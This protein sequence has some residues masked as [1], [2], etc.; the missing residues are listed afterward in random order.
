MLFRE[1]AVMGTSVGSHRDAFFRRRTGSDLPGFTVR[2][3]LAPDVIRTDRV[4]DEVHPFAVWRPCRKRAAP[5]GGTYGE[6]GRPSIR[7]NQ[8]ASQPLPTSCSRHQ[9]Q[10]SSRLTFSCSPGGTRLCAAPWR[11]LMRITKPAPECSCL[12]REAFTSGW[13]GVS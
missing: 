7:W 1:T 2:E 13:T 4:R 6:P 10:F 5:A 9:F 8:P 3:V 12:H 11:S